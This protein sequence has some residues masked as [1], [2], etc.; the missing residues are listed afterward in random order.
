[1]PAKEMN[2]MTASLVT[3]GMQVSSASKCEAGEGTIEIDGK[4][5]ATTI[6]LF[7]IQNGIGVVSPKKELVSPEVGDTVICEIVKLNEKNGEAMIIEI[8]GKPGSIQPD[9]LY[10][11]FHVTGIVDRYMHQT[12][13]AVRRRDVCRALVK[14]VSPVVRIDFRERD[15]C[16][17]LHAI[18]PSCG[19][20]LQAQL[21]GDWNVKCNT[22][23]YQAFRALADNFNAGWA[24]LDQGASNLNNSGKRWG[25]VAESMFSKGPSG[26][27]T[28]IAEDVRE[29]GRERTYFRFES[30]GGG[31]GQ[32]RP[33]HNPGCKLF[34]GG[35][36]RE[37]GTDELREMFAK[38]GDMVDCIVP[39]DENK[40]NRGF[41]FVTYSEKSEAEAA[42]SELDGHKIN[43]RRIGVRDA[44]S[45]D[46]KK[47]GKR[48]D[49]EGA[50]LYIGNLPF[51]ATEEQLREVF[52]GVATITG[53]NIITDNA[54]KPK[55][56]AFAF[57]KEKDKV[58]EIVKSVNGSELLGRKIRVDVAQQK[59]RN[60]NSGGKPEKSSR[61]LRAMREEEED[62][63]KRN[64]RPRPKKD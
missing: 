18:C 60:N 15:D 10:G 30:D 44:D 40:V 56:F 41:G 11:Q 42:A 23:S 26:R 31:R 17:V 52:K 63:K 19:D 1:M 16:G 43:G 9:H 51:K 54:G 38:F 13:D 50:K 20:T 35:L 39:T 21:D 55:G 8:E 32:Q 46:K 29:D 48:K 28:F 25:S 64:R 57:V 27:A 62:S 5:V 47:K 22:C 3:P 61:E 49:P 33:R 12:A 53:L 24:E 58:E 14:E 4:I 6:G 37:I 34:I 59:K 2:N 45:D 7:T 36:P